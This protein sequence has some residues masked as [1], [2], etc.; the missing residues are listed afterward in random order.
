MTEYELA[1]YLTTLLGLNAEGGSSELHDFDVSQAGTL[2]DTHLPHKMNGE[3]FANQL[4][5]FGLYSDNVNGNSD[6]QH[7]Q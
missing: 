6:Q 5:G 1:E 3:L 4:L 2:I 7:Q